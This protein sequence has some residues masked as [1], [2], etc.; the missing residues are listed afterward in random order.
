MLFDQKP[1]KYM[2]PRRY[3][4]SYYEYIDRSARKA[5]EHIRILL[6][7]WFSHFPSYHQNDLKSRFCSSD[8]SEF[9]SAFFELYIYKLLLRLGFEM[10][11]HPDIEGVSTHPEFLVNLNNNPIF[12]FESTLAIGSHDELAAEK[13][14]NVVYDTINRMESP[15]FFIGAIVQGTPKTPP[16]GAKWRK[17]LKIKLSELDP[18]QVAFHF[19]EGE[20][21]DLPSWRTEYDGWVVIFQAIPKSPEARGKPGTRPIGIRTEGS[22]ARKSE[23]N[24]RNV[25][26]K[27]ATKYGRLNLPYIISINIMHEFCDNI[28]IANALYGEE[29]IIETRTI[30]GAKKFRPG[31]ELNGVWWGPI[32]PRNTRVSA[33]LIFKQLFPWSI[34]QNTPV[35]W[36]NPWAKIPLNPEILTLP[37]KLFNEK[38]IYKEHKAGK[39]AGEV[40]NLP[41]NWPEIE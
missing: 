41:R 26:E 30:N 2:R 17:F 10:K 6:N 9:L 32:G 7:D 15:N 8:D 4:E 22:Q 20:L 28:S 18:D 40:F 1:R 27:K 12:Y 5:C 31:R 25:I 37:Q 13:L 19:M 35:L 21:K 14:K 38:G 24:I 11:I 3:S 29:I 39:S 23:I 16:P 33:V 34:A 36:H